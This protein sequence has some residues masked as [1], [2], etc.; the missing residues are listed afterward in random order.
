[1]SQYQVDG[2]TP[3]YNDTVF[4]REDYSFQ[5]NKSNIYRQNLYNNK[6]GVPIRNLYNITRP[7]RYGLLDPYTNSTGQPVPLP[8]N[9]WKY[10]VSERR[11]YYPGT[12]NDGAF[13]LNMAKVEDG[14]GSIQGVQI[15]AE[16]YVTEYFYGN[17]Q[18]G[19]CETRIINQTLSLRF[20]GNPPLVFKPGMPFE[21]AVAVRYH[22]QVAL[23]EDLLKDSELE[24]I[25][26][27]KDKSGQIT[28]LPNLKVPRVLSDQ[29][30]I[31]QDIDRLEHYGQLTGLEATQDV[32]LNPTNSDNKYNINPAS[33]FTDDAEKNTEFLFHD[34]YAKE[35]SYEEYRKTGVHRFTFDVPEKT[36]EIYMTAYYSDSKT[37]TRAQAE[38]TAY[39]SYGPQDRHIY[40]RTNNRY[41][42]VGEYVVFNVKTNFPLQHFDWIIISKNLIINS[43]REYGGDLIKM[44][45][46]FSV[47]V[48]SEMAPGFH[49]MVYAVTRPDD[50]LLSDSAY[51]P[52]QAINRHKIEFKL[53]QIKDHMMDTVECTCRGDPG[54]VFLSSTV[55]SAVFA[56]Q[57]KNMITK[58]SILESLHTFE[59]ERRHLHRVFFTDREGTHPDQV[60]YYPAMD[61]GVDTNRTIEMKELII[62]TDFLTIPQT[63]LT[64]Q[65]NITAGLFPCL[66]KGCYEADQICDG[67]KDCEDGLDESECGDP[68]V[69]AQEQTL[70]FR[71]SRF[72]RY[73]DFYDV[74]DGEWGWFDEN[75]DEDREQFIVRDI[76]LTTD[77]WYFNVFS[78]SKV[79]GIAILDEPEPFD[80]IRPIH[81]YCEAPEEVHRGESVG[82]RCM[83]MNRSPYDLETVIIL[84]GSDQYEFI[85]VEQYG[86]VKSYNPATSSGDHH[87]LMFIRGEDEMEVHL[88]IKPKPQKEQGKITVRV[89]LRTQIM[90]KTR[91]LSIKILPEGSL[92]HR[93]TSV[94]LDLKNRANY[95]EFMNIIIDETPIKPYEIYRRYIFGSPYGRVSISG[96]VIGPTFIDEEPARL[97]RMFP[98]GNGRWGKGAEYHLFN[99]AANTWQL[100]YYRLTNQFHD[101]GVLKKQVFEQM[102]VEYTAVMRRFS[103]QGWVSI[104]DHSK[105]SV[106]LTAYTIKVLEAASFQD[107]EDYI[108]IDP[109]VF[110]SAVMW[111]LNY[112][113]EEGAFQETEYFSRPLHYAMFSEDNKNIS[114]TAHCLIALT[115][116][117][118]KLQGDVKR[119]SNTG[120]QRAIKYLEK[121]LAKITDP[122]ELA[123]TAYALTVSR[124]SEANSAYGMLL[125]K[126]I[127]RGGKVYWS[128]TQIK[129]NRVRYEFNRPFLEHKD[130]QTNDALAVEATSYALLT[131]FLVEGGG[132][133]I[134]QDQVTDWLNTMRMGDGGFI[135]TVDTIVAL[136]ALV[137][138]SYNN[139]INDITELNVEVNLPD[140]NITEN[141]AV[142]GR[143]ALG[144][145]RLR[146]INIPNVWGTL[147]VHAS[148]AGQAVVQLDTNHGIDYEPYKVMAQS[149]RDILSHASERGKLEQMQ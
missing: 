53:T 64:R 32:R 55:R 10:L 67:R 43:G 18:K 87:H 36:E 132:V 71:L 135:A 70:R 118:D 51:F 82:I 38:T 66:K 104:W 6:D 81:F 49:I 106:W 2:V 61:Y 91:E 116:T 5:T 124:S 54:A 34:L 7:D 121:H 41:I 50:Y 136:E 105:P 110:G 17:T 75:I 37:S 111:L 47:V 31:F 126:K 76:P 22:D 77:R 27:M 24:I 40:I 119:F 114:L 20:V 13:Y 96:D 97:E 131:L 30:N 74:G 107:W 63:P 73:S 46:T 15:R 141:V 44:T 137:T 45:N 58:A 8:F 14:M 12:K 60:I 68:A 33:F 143:Q 147:N 72:N 140:S 79:H 80:S 123:I 115:E 86:Y 16:A 29:F 142:S 128:R 9:N 138:Y 148:G 133:T 1:M 100:H 129:T 95:F 65:C 42:Q 25:I 127:E 78:I 117:A 56:T 102:N 98:D 23:P 139:R 134:L 90:S 39:G 83:I 28:T 130:L 103:S 62:F 57:G 88:P 89:S 149:S 122:Y 48:S 99:L 52:V 84:E 85:H 26:R 35:K 3:L 146:T 113:S 101:M 93:H 145:S 108:Y 11:A 59:N 125:K 112:Q 144:I 92:V 69:F 120:R 21:G 94:M 109:K 19:W 4:Y